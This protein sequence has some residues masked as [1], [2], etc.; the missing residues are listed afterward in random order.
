LCVS[1]DTLRAGERSVNARGSGSM[2]DVPGLG[3]DVDALLSD[4]P[5]APRPRPTGAAARPMTEAGPPARHAS[6]LVSAN[7]GLAEQVEA[8]HEAIDTARET[9]HHALGRGRTHDAPAVEAWLALMDEVLNFGQAMTSALK[10]AQ[11]QSMRRN[12]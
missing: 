1:F 12:Q 9:L 3:V 10:G 11:S 7:R 8:C 6:E 2:W 4:K 5:A